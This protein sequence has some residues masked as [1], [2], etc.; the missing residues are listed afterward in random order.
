ME[1]R[2]EEEREGERR[3]E[4]LNTGVATNNQANTHSKES[5]VSAS[6]SGY[7]LLP[8]PQ[9]TAHKCSRSARRWHYSG[10]T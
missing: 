6:L 2:R 1:G 8:A 9:H 10:P 7:G 3:K 5:G 4:K